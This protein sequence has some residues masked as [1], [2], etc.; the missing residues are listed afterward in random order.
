MHRAIATSCIPS[1]DFASM[2]QVAF[3]LQTVVD[4]LLTVPQVDKARIA[5]TGYSRGGK[6]ALIA[7]AL[8]DRIAAVV[9]GGVPA[10]AALLPGV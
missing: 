1:T 3:T 8:D 10:S 5:L 9:T 6:M 7:A 4:H 2:G